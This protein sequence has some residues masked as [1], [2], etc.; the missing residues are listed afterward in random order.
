MLGSRGYVLGYNAQ[1]LVD[2]ADGIVLAAE[3]IRDANDFEAAPK[4]LHAMKGQG[5]DLP[6][7]I[8]ADSNYDS[9]SAIGAV[10]EAGVETCIRLHSE[11]PEYAGENAEG[12]LVCRAGRPLEHRY[13]SS[14]GEGKGVYDYYGLAECKGCPLFEACDM[15]RKRLAVPEGEDL[16]ARFRNRDRQKNCQGA[17]MRRR[18]IE[19]TFGDLKEHHRFRRFRRRGLA[20]ARAEFVL[21]ACTY[22]I[23]KLIRKEA[24]QNKDARRLLALLDT[25]FGAVAELLSGLDRPQ[26]ARRRLA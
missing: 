14:K 11:L 22:N 9:P 10:E 24:E 4:V 20:K 5:K 15:K 21:W 7:R 18:R 1:V 25:V 8:V 23:F 12:V 2:T 13:T 6:A 16:A 17:M 19:K 26:S 3:V